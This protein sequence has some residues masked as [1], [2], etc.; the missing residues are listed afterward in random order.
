VRGQ[1]FFDTAEYEFTRQIKLVD[2]VD[3]REEAFGSY[4]KAAEIYAAKVPQLPRGQWTMEP[5]QMWFYVMLGASDLSQLTRAAARSDPGLKQIGEAMRALPGE[6]AEVHLTQFGEML[7]NVLAQ[8][9]ANMKQRFLSAGLQIVGP[10]HPSA[11]TAAN[12]LNSYQELLDEVQLRLTIDGLTRV[13]YHQPFGAF[14]SLEHSRQLARESGGFSKYLQNQST[15]SRAYMYVYAGSQKPTNHRDEFTKN[16]HSALDET[17][18]VV[19]ITFHDANVKNIE[20]ARD[21]WQETPFAYLVLRAKD[22]AVDRIPSLQLDMDFS[23]QAG[24]VILPI[25]SQVQPIDAKEAV[26]PLR[27]LQ[28]LTVSFTLDEREWREGKLVVEIASKAHGLIPS[29]AQLFNFERPGFDVDVSDN[30]LSVTQF[31]SDG[32][33]KIAHADRGWQFTYRRKKD[34]R[35]DLPFQFPALLPGIQTTSAEYKHYQD[36][37]LVT[38][39][40]KQALAGI[41]LK[42]P[43]SRGL[44]QAAAALILAVLAMAVW[45]LVRR[46]KRRAQVATAETAL[47]LPAHLTP[48]SVVAF[49]QRLDRQ[50]ASR[51]DEPGR[52]E[53]QTQIRELEA[54]FFSGTTPGHGPLDLE[55]TART[56]QRRVANQRDQ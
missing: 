42:A 47:A 19:S 41:M 5:Y 30:G 45:A 51:L 9:P 49:L 33:N 50:Y 4:R 27:P 20:L 2:Y 56:W 1:L 55:S 38:V 37:D 44:R 15:Q 34:L 10:D 7:G 26:P 11:K 18:D 39:Q 23:D 29:H 24:Q 54:V 22:A 14:L 25:R 21:G 35:G 52:Q 16:I 43:A 13:G 17:F 46:R 3:L 32:H 28:D 53:L 40:P 12:A 31:E 48:F 6:A 36:A 8:V